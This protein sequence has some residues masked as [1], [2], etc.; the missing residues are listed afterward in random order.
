[1]RVRAQST[2]H[3][4]ESTG[5]G[6][7]GEVFGDIAD[8]SSTAGGSVVVPVTKQSFGK[9]L[10]DFAMQK[11]LDA[12]RWPEVRFEIGAVQVLSTDPWRVSIEGTVH[13]KK[14]TNI[15]VEASGELGEGRIEARATFPLSL[16]SVGVK[17]PQ[18]L[19]LK[20]DDTVEVEV[21]IV[22]EASG[23]RPA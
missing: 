19:F 12:K 21:L 22:A 11:H 2:L 10:Q 23:T 18:M 17:P 15:T 5:A 20:V 4:T 6:L 16:S 13:Y 8:L 9:R 14:T 7:S 3:P 1:V